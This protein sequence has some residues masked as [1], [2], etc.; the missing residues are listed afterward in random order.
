MIVAGFGFR[1][2]ASADSLKSALAAARQGHKI[3]AVATLTQKAHALH[4][5]GLDVIDVPLHEAQSQTTPTRSKAS[6][7]AYG[8]GSVAEATALAAAGPNARLVARRIVSPDGLAT[9]ALAEGDRP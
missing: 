2:S 6:L 5:L 7:K 3:T 8:V 9:C 1:Q 4:A